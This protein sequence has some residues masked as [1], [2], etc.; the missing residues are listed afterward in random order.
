VLALFTPIFEPQNAGIR[1]HGGGFSAES[2]VRVDPELG[3]N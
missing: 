3:A 1:A 2:N